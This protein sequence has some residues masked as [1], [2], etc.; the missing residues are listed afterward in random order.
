M[1]SPGMEI[2]TRIFW[3]WD[4]CTSWVLNQPG[5]HNIGCANEYSRSTDT[6]VKDYTRLIRWCGE[7]GVDGV[8][9]WG[10]LRDCHGGEESVHRLCEEAR[11]SGVMLLAGVGLNAYGGVYY[12][13]K[14]PYSLDNHLRNH[15][16]LLALNEQGEPHILHGPRPM[17]HACPSRHENQEFA[18]ESL[19]YLFE[20]FDIAGV[21]METGDTGVCQCDACKKRRGRAIKG[22]GRPSWEDMALIYP[23][24]AKAIRSVK[25][26]AFIVAETYSHPEPSDDPK[27]QPY[28]GGGFPPWGPDY[29]SQFPDDIVVQWV[30]DKYTLGANSW[31]DRG[32]PPAGP[33]RH[34][35]RAHY[36]TLWMDKLDNLALDRIAELARQSMAHGFD[37][38]SLFGERSPFNAN[39]EL[40][41]LAF[42]D[43]G[44]HNNPQADLDSFLDRI[45]A[46]LLGG[47]EQS[48]AYLRI[49][50]LADNSSGANSGI[51]QARQH[52]AALKGD[53]ARRW[54]WLANY[55]SSHAWEAAQ[56]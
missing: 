49:A 34:M 56:G 19:R 29:L 31:T 7:H 48:R 43:L 22:I 21:Q 35:M 4:H 25:P 18:G 47:P 11:K 1:I 23:I 28:F 44:S 51:R 30:G 6:F 50:R 20:T 17:P 33:R 5:E 27:V 8:V 46:P 15:P 39:A 42:V 41:Y 9:V 2:K 12:E 16:E 37:C 38:L 55:L 32:I 53:S 45:A 40:N 36:A 24:A 26:D 54:T 10:L 14:S 13:G 3:T 52:A